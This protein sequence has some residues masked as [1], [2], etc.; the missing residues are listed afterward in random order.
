MFMN[1]PCGLH[2]NPYLMLT[3]CVSYLAAAQDITM[4]QGL[5]LVRH[6]IAAALLATAIGV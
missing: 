4:T 5:H 1:N 2:L 3:D 6:V